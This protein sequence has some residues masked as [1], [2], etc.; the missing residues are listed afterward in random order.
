MGGL[1]FFSLNET[2]EQ[3][4]GHCETARQML[5]RA[6]AQF[7]ASQWGVFGLRLGFMKRTKLVYYPF[8]TH[9][10]SGRMFNLR[11]SSPW[12]EPYCLFVCLLICLF[13]CVYHRSDIT[14]CTFSGLQILVT[15]CNDVRNG[16][17][18]NYM[19]TSKHSSTQ[20]LNAI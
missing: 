5:G 20:F 14:I 17:S 13:V 7:L 12:F 15:L 9:C 8:F 11:P 18:Y 3:H 4:I 19:A 10:C 1:P 2:Q 16:F 6:F